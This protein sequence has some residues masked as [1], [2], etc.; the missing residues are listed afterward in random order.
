MTD[1]NQFTFQ[2]FKGIAQRDQI[3]STDRTMY[4]IITGST[5]SGC[6]FY[7]LSIQVILTNYAAMHFLI[8]RNRIFIIL[9]NS[10]DDGYLFC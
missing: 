7:E 1:G 2:V 3:L 4:I 10:M 6:N 8:S 9:N 5:S